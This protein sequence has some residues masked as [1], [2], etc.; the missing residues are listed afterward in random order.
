MAGGSPQIW[1]GASY[2]QAAPQ[3]KSCNFSDIVFAGRE[4][5]GPPSK[6]DDDVTGEYFTELDEVPAKFHDP[7]H[8]KLLDL[9]ESMFQMEEEDVLKEKKGKCRKNP[10][11]TRVPWTDQE[12]EEIRR[13]FK[14]YFMKK[15]RPKPA[16]CQKALNASK[17]AGGV[18]W[19]RS[20]STLKK[21]V[22]RMIDKL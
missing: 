11:Q 7:V 2:F 4:E 8:E 3:Y 10:C 12:E 13:L 6:N 18:I 1:S 16:F 5:R 17:L 19:Q 14:R 15:E 22:F 9:S 21:M 20:K